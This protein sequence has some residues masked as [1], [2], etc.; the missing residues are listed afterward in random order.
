MGM[1]SRLIIL[2]TK[3]LEATAAQAIGRITNVAIPIVVLHSH[4]PNEATDRFFFTFSIAFFLFGTLGNALTDATVPKV[5]R[6]RPILHKRERALV[7]S[8]SAIISVILILSWGYLNNSTISSG[9]IFGAALSVG[10]GFYATFSS[11]ILHAERR[12]I[13]PGILWGLRAVPLIIY[14]TAHLEITFLPWLMVGIGV[15]DLLRSILL[16]KFEKNDLPTTHSLTSQKD[17]LLIIMAASINGLIPIIDRIIA[18]LDTP[19]GISLL[20]SGERI[21][22]VIASLSTIGMLNI[23]LVELSRYDEVKEFNKVWHKLLPLSTLWAVSWMIVALVFWQLLKEQ[24]VFNLWRFSASQADIT[25]LVFIYYTAGLPAFVVGLVC[26]RAYIVF[27]LQKELLVL[28]AVSLIS[29]I[30]LSILLFI[31]QGIPG[32]AL[33]TSVVYAILTT[34]MI[35]RL[36]KI[37]LK[38]FYSPLAFDQ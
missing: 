13:W 1:S 38:R 24:L 2:F 8:L 12:Y 37:K 15:S 20:E 10:A 35:F 18:G 23:V 6:Q 31:I 17:Y 34:I 25:Y 3:G 22:G 16:G 27:G 26:V 11:G 19:G 33:A 32:I 5:A 14:A 4:S 30:I 36:S 21:Y 28:S 29:N 7:S 9:L